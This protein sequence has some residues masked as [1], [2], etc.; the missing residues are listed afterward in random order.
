MLQS[1]PNDLA[2][3]VNER[4]PKNLKYVTRLADEY[5]EAHRGWGRSSTNP[6]S[7][8]RQNKPES[9][10]PKDTFTNQTK[11]IPDQTTGNR[12]LTC[13]FCHKSGHFWRQCRLALNPLR[14]LWR[15]WLT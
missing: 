10:R 7:G 1:V 11:R 15:C 6:N 14:L 8:E 3:F 12:K 9:S 13:H 2:M 4:K 5:V